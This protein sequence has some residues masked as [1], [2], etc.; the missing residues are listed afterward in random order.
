MA[1]ALVQKNAALEDGHLR[2]A[3]EPLPA[4]PSDRWRRPLLVKTDAEGR[5]KLPTEPGPAAVLIV[6]DSGV[7]EL[8]YDQFRKSP[9]V[10]LDRWGRIEGRV[11]WKDIARRGRG[12]DAQRLSGRSMVI[13]A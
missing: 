11:L 7:K 2:G 6:H 3:D 8:S 9:E 5:F 4:E 12:S 1:L 13:P 10:V